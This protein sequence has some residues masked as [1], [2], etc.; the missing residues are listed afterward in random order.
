MA[1]LSVSKKS[2]KDLLSS[3]KTD[4][5]IPDYQRPYAW[6]AEKECQTLWEDVILFAFP[7]NDVN[8]FDIQVENGVATITCLNDDGLKSIVS[9]DPTNESMS[10]TINVTVCDLIFHNENEPLP[11]DV[12]PS[13]RG[14]Y[15]VVVKMVVED[16]NYC[17]EK[18]STALL[19][20]E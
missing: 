11:S 13:L 12:L 7:D 18:E 16:K 4:F 3:N 14:E 2:I 9:S 5:L 17:G 6:D 10:L 15:I 20:I 8:N 1:E 19:I